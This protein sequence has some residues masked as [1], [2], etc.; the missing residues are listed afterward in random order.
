M[1]NEMSLPRLLHIAVFACFV[2]FGCGSKT[3]ITSATNDASINDASQNDASQEPALCADRQGG[4]LIEFAFGP[5]R[6][7]PWTVWITNTAFINEAI[8]VIGKPPGRV[9]GFQKLI[10]GTDCDPKH[11]WHPDPEM[12]A[13]ADSS[14]EVCDGRPSDIDDDPEYWINT[15]HNFCPW[16]IVVVAVDDRR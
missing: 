2:L 5:T 14:T 13:W 11:A 8:T 16:S 7:Q 3:H 1:I 9:G 10:V 12:V 4:A 6:A 15:L